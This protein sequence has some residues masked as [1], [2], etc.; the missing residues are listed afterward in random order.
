MTE[1]FFSLVSN[2]GAVVIGLATFLSCLALPIPASVVM[3]AGG[4]FVASGDLGF[5][6]VAGAAFGGAVAGDQA[7][8]RAARHGGQAIAA[9]LGRN[10]A[11]AAA[12]AR[13]RAFVE[14]W[15][16][17]G[18][19]LSRW[20]LSPLGPWVNFA[21]GA[22]AMD[23][24]SFTVSGALGEALWVTIYVGLGYAFATQIDALS[25]VLG[26][27]VAAVTALAVAAGLGILLV[28]AARRRP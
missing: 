25:A 3:L 20:L 19:F 16:V 1:V 4:A 5:P 6:A 8:F 26:N 14:R 10:P 2:Y 11:R 12:L 17:V 24:F 28:R 27:A 9:R 15:G 22:A 13:S 18:V 21:A 23:T 7:G